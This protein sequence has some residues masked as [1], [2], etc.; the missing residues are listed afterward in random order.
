MEAAR[1][2]KALW[3]A[4]VAAVLIGATLVYLGVGA[5]RA[6]EIGW[7]EYIREMMELVD[8]VSVTPAGVAGFLLAGAG[9]VVAAFLL[10]RRWSTP[11]HGTTEHVDRSR[12]VTL[13]WWGAAALAVVGLLTALISL[14]APVAYFSY[15]RTPYPATPSVFEEPMLSLN[16]VFV[17]SPTFVGAGLVWAGLLA[18]SF[19]LGRYRKLG[20]VPTASL[21]GPL[22]AAP[23]WWCGVTLTVIGPAV[24]VISRVT[25]PSPLSYRDA[26]PAT[27]PSNTILGID[28]PGVERWAAAIFIGTALT[29]VGLVVM[30][31]VVAHSRAARRAPVAAAADDGP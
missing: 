30:C 27:L 21:P 2:E 20:R 25:T 26:F 11:R 24:V 31:V 5:A 28:D 16:S 13:V 15:D 3:A 23:I 19:L 6:P 8:A 4:A 10:G 17:A 1:R 22:R 18:M 12:V 7:F 14:S 9:T 29:I